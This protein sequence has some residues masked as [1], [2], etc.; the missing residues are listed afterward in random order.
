[1][2]L[3]S[4]LQAID[5]AKEQNDADLWEDL[6]K[7]AESKPSESRL[8]RTLGESKA[9]VSILAFIRGLLE[10]VGPEV[11][12]IRLI[13]RIKNGL[14]IPGLKPAIIKILQDFNIQISLIEGCKTI[15]NADCRSLTLQLY[16]G[17]TNASLGSIDTTMCYKC[18]KPA[19]LPSQS[20]TSTPASATTAE[21]TSIIFLCRHIFHISCALPDVDLPSRPQH[22]L[23]PLLAG[24]L[25]ISGDKGLPRF[26]Q[27]RDLAA[28]ILFASQLKSRS[29]LP[30]SCPACLAGK[31]SRVS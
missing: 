19:F 31:G 17:Q 2:Q 18:R 25:T 29:S 22:F 20:S 5:F 8:Y 7:Y 12:P 24:A 11:D 13:R 16:D 1:M 26:D 15:L 14:E 28:K 4:L 6:L 27:E 21:A 10:N 3:L 30:I 9:E 23:N